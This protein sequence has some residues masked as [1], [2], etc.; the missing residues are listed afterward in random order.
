MHCLHTLPYVCVSIYI[1]IYIY[2]LVK[3]PHNAAGFMK[4]NGEKGKK[5]Y[6][7]YNKKMCKLFS[8]FTRIDV[9]VYRCDEGW[10][11]S[12]FQPMRNVLGADALQRTHW[13]GQTHLQV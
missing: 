6:S 1:Y 7:L 8:I 9:Q 3:Y 12:H 10:F 5:M 13:E 2:I 11:G 4:I